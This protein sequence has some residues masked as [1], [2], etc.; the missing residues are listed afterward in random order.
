MTH[1]TVARVL[2]VLTLVVAAPALAE[3]ADAPPPAD[4]LQPADSPAP[5]DSPQPADTSPAALRQ[6]TPGKHAGVE[7]DGWPDLS[8]FLDEKYG[9]LPVVMPIT[10]PAVGYGAAGGVAF[11]SKPL[12]QSNEGLGR[13]NITFVGAM[14]TANGSWGAAA[15]DSR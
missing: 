14:G 11:L 6:K 1:A 15:G 7:D 8:G 4:T 3:A 5:A 2:G 12:G 10:E 9:F 13:P